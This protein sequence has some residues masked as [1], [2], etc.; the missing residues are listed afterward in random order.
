MRFCQVLGEDGTAQTVGGI[1]RSL[2]C[3]VF[4]LER[5]DYDKGSKHFLAVNPH[6]V[7]HVCKDSGGDEEALAVDIF[8]RFAT[9]GQGRPFG[10]SR[11][12]VAEHLLVLGL[13][14]L[15]ALECIIGERITNFANVLDLL[16]EELH[17]F[18]VDGLL[19][20]DAGCCCAYLTHVRHD[21]SMAPLHGLIQISV[22][23]DKEGAFAACFER[24]IFEIYAGCFHY[25][26]RSGG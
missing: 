26:A 13:R 9:C 1:V 18:I 22:S 25:L 12:Y 10:F 8:V 20:Q 19:N 5:R 3:L 15:G 14:N 2:N 23:E 11:F 4:G 6:A 24:D 16:F 7:F 17:K 21:T